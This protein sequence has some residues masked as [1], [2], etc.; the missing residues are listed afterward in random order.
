MKHS[1][2][3]ICAAA[4][5]AAA[6]LN[7]QAQQ[8]EAYPQGNFYPIDI[9]VHPDGSVAYTITQSPSYSIRRGDLGGTDWQEIA[10][11]QGFYLPNAIE[12]GPDGSVYLAGWRYLDDGTTRV[13]RVWISSDGGTSWRE[14]ADFLTRAVS[15]MAVDA[16]GNVF[17]NSSRVVGTTSQYPVT[18]LVTYK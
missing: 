7:T 6:L 1:H 16:A 3:I 13:A 8:W 9:A 5:F 4:L 10:R 15:D 11:P 14:V 12:V 18:R 2:S 17:I